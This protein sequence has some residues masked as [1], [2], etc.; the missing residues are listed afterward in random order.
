[1]IQSLSTA[2]AGL[3]AQQQKIDIIANN[4][5]NVNTI[6]FRSADA[7]F[8]DTYYTVME[9]PD[10]E[11][12]NANLQKGTGVALSSTTIDFS[13]GGIQTTGNVLD[14]MIDGDAFFK[15]ETADGTYAYTKDG[16]FN[17]SA[18]EDGYYLINSKG[19]YVLD[20]NDE[21]ILIPE[22][23]GEFTV[24][25]D[26]SIIVDGDESKFGIYTFENNA[27]LLCEGGNLFSET[28][29]SGA[30]AAAEEYAVMQGTLEGSNVDLAT[31][32]TELIQA[33]RVFSLASKALQTADDMEGLANN[34][35][36]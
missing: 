32:L 31:E 22:D 24:N 30:V 25:S 8:E 34:I 11:A 35:R 26:G 1:M 19:Y 13:Q 10:P 23:A 3:Y 14:F 5:A 4:I 12:E 28:A 7:R 17:I 15:L 9:N 33:Q 21:R 16:S 27:G 36:R 2:A 29:V 20:E 6:A 18:E